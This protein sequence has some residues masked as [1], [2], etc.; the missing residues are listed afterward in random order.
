MTEARFA[1]R[2]DALPGHPPPE[3]VEVAVRPAALGEWVE[4]LF[5]D[6]RIAPSGAR[7]AL[8]LAGSDPT[9]RLRAPE[10]ALEGLPLSG[11]V[12]SLEV[13][14]AQALVRNARPAVALH[15]AAVAFSRGALL[16]TGPG[17]RGKSSL[18]AGLAARGRPVY[19]DDVVLVD[20]DSAE[21]RPFKRLLKVGPGARSAL[22][23]PE[24]AGP[25]GPLWDDAHYHPRELGASWAEPARACAAVLPERRDGEEGPALVSVGGGEAVREVLLQLLFRSERGAEEF[26]LAARVL[27]GARLHRLRFSRSDQAVALL[28][29][30][31]GQDPQEL[32]G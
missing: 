13:A 16:F 24:P 2:V 19:G 22:G 1:Y 32:E 9:L 26:D 5:P 28:E 8:E 10:G 25:L 15:G 3:A 11:A 23:L 31:L 30:R 21:I 4:P 14:L 29:A 7:P 17:G 6:Y 12:A 18:T 27:D 20:P